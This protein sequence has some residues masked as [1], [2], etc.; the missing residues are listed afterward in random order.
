MT[1]EGERHPFWEEFGVPVPPLELRH[2]YARALATYAASGMDEEAIL[3][4]CRRSADEHEAI[5]VDLRIHPPQRPAADIRRWEEVAAV[6]TGE[7]A[8]PALLTMR[9]DFPETPHQNMAPE[10]YPR[11]PCV[12]DQSWDDAAAGWTPY[13]YLARVRWWLNAAAMGELTGTGQFIDPLFVPTGPNLL[14][15]PSLAG[16][17]ENGTASALVFPV[18]SGGEH[19]RCLRLVA[20]DAAPSLPPAN[21]RALWLT[22]PATMAR[23][24]EMSPDNLGQLVRRAADIGLD[25]VERLRSWVTD[26]ARDGWPAV[27]LLLLSFPVTAGAD[28]MSRQDTVAFELGPNVGHLGVMLGV[29]CRDSDETG[30]WGRL[31]PPYVVD[32]DL[33]QAQRLR[34]MAVQW[35][36]FLDVARL[37]SGVEAKATTGAVLVGAGAIGSHVALTL[38]REGRHSWVIVDPDWLRPHNLAR[39]VLGQEHVG[40][41]KAPRL[42]DILSMLGNVR[43]HFIACDVHHPGEHGEALQAAAKEAEVIIDASASVA[44]ARR[45]SDWTFSDARRVSVFFNPSGTDVVLLAED[46]ARGARLDQLEAVYYRT[47]LRNETVARHLAP[48][49]QGFRYAGSCR[50]VSAR[51]PESRVAVLSGLAAG[52]ISAALDGE[53]ADVRV[54]SMQGDGSVSVARTPAT[55]GRRMRCGDWTVLLDDGLAAEVSAQRQAALPA[56]TGGSLVGVV[57]HRRRVI[58]VVD[59]LPPPP[60][61]HGDPGGFERGTEDLVEVLHRISARTAGMVR[62]IGEWHTHPRGHA[63]KPSV[64]DLEQLLILRHELRREGLPA[65]M[66]ISGADG[67]SVVLLDGVERE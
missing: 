62:Y 6:F 43:A 66:L 48:P 10:G 38:T 63:S 52:G 47:L 49:P 29:F 55:P 14:L 9:K 8:Q 36:F 39:H 23:S 15:H 4:E 53:H 17:R 30:T 44:A 56:E 41:L 19:P 34:S 2:P 51:I 20:A 12:S 1:M 21:Y 11:Y 60:D 13:S 27:P 58:A 7:H 50:A 46:A 61:S 33:L 35:D 28:D 57:D 67:E 25:L 42:A 32:A 31:L 45:I 65:T 40:D 18:G 37:L 24:I 59:A 3:V 16:S 54:W 5:L 22:A 26:M 64:V